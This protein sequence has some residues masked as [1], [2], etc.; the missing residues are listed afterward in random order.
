MT[1]EAH[2]ILILGEDAKAAGELEKLLSPHGYHVRRHSDPE[3]IFRAGSPSI[4]SC[5]LVGDRF[6]NGMSGLG[7]LSQLKDRGWEI[8]TVFLASDW[9][10]QSVVATMRAG[11]DGFLTRPLNQ[12][13]LL[14]SVSHALLRAQS[15]HSSR[16]QE[17]QVQSRLQSLTP[18]ELEILKLVITGMLNK[19][20]AD[21]LSLALVTVKVHR[22]RIMSKLRA[23]NPAELA[24]IASLAGLVPAKPRESF[25]AG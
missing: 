8:P 5:L 12:A 19:E 9:D 6:E 4:P 1:R 11:A 14:D 24:H 3:E 21:Q 10:V 22:A 7:V 17:K 2:A 18:R 13:D 23:G 25:L 20:I 16:K 15:I